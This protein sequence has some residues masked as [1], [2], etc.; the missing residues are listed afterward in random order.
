MGAFE[1][2]ETEGAAEAMSCPEPKKVRDECIIALK[3]YDCIR[4]QDCLTPSEIGPA[5]AAECM[6]IGADSHKEG[7]IVR[8]PEKAATVTID[9]LCVKKIIIVDKQPSPF[10]QGYWDVDIKYVFEYRLTFRE[11]D[12]SVIACIKANSIFN[13]KLCLFGSVGSDLAI[14]TD[15]LRPFL[16]SATFDAEPFIWVEAKA[17]ALHAKIHKS[18]RHDHHD[19]DC[20]GHGEVQVTLGLFSIVKLFRIV[21]LNVQSTGFCVPHECED[22]CPVNPCDYFEDLDFPMDIFTPPQRPEFL[23]GVSANIPNKKHK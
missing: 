14:G 20:H 1:L 18:H 10:R 9:H 5:R 3:V 8:P 4:R 12:G 21:N 15:L 7:E 2:Q 17:V 6:S 19:D 13:M 23:T 22:V 11:A 16:D